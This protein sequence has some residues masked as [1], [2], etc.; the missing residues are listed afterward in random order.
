[1]FTVAM[2]SA[3]VFPSGR[4]ENRIPEELSNHFHKLK[5]FHNFGVAVIPKLN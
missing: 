1:M 2:N 4:V 5:N 3:R